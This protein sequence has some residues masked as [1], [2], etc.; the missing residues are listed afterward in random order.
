MRMTRKIQIASLGVI[1]NGIVALGVL[2]PQQALAGCNQM[3]DT[4]Q[5]IFTCS[6]KGGYC[7][8]HIPSGCSQVT[9][10]ECFSG[11]LCNGVSSGYEMLCYYQ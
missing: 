7:E 6:Q 3:T 11:V 2:G 10:S 1:L 9:S 4:C 5:Y 8:S